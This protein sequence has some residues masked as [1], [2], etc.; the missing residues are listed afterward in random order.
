MRNRAGGFQSEPM[1]MIVNH[2]NPPMP[3][4][5]HRIVHSKYANR[6][7]WYREIHFIFPFFASAFAKADQPGF[8]QIKTYKVPAGFK[9]KQASILIELLAGDAYIAILAA[10]TKAKFRARPSVAP[11]FSD[12][13]RWWPTGMRRTIGGIHNWF[14]HLCSA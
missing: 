5:N 2:T 9:F 4:H 6:W 7:L 11:Q 10:L 13:G 8:M 14:W 3:K 1:R 12:N